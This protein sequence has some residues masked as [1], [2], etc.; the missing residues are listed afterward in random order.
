MTPKVTILKI[1]N[2]DTP[3]FPRYEVLLNEHFVLRTF[4]GRRHALEYADSVCDELGLPRM[5]WYGTKVNDDEVFFHV[6]SSW[7][8]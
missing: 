5:V 6:V 1:V 2:R 8:M 7:R 3:Y 4:E